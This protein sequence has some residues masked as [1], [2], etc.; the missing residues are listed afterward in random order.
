MQ[1]QANISYIVIVDKLV[2]DP[3]AFLDF[4]VQVLMVYIILYKFGC[5][6]NGCDFDLE[7]I[8]AVL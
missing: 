3:N 4:I 2:S 8:S 7:Q 1:L 6:P 5:S